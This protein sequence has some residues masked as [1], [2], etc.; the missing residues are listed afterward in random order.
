MKVAL[1]INDKESR[2]ELAGCIADKGGTADEYPTAAKALGMLNATRYDSILMHWQAHPGLKPSDP[3]IK[4][5]AT[6][7]PVVTMNRNVLYWE[8]ALRVIDIIRVEESPNKSTPVIV[9]FP[10]LGESQFEA[11]DRLSKEA[12]ES[13]LAERQP[14]TIISGVSQDTIIQAL[15]PHL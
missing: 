6:M 2:V 11:G 5:I 12:V 7:L 1:L 14:A 9:I 15:T 8:T 10:G 3:Q 13:D 4:Q